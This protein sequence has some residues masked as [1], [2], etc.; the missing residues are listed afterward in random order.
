MTGGWRAIRLADGVLHLPCSGVSSMVFVV[1]LASL[2][3][4]VAPQSNE[5]GVENSGVGV[6]PTGDGLAAGGCSTDGYKRKLEDQ[7]AHRASK[8]PRSH[9]PNTYVRIKLFIYCHVDS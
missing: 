3:S 9:S 8:N 5:G 2:K 1:V 4:E 6:V 7:E